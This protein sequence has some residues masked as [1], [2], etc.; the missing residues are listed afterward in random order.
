MARVVFWSPD[1]SMTGTTHALIAVATAMGIN[2]KTS[3]L[4][5]NAHFNSKKIETAFT[6]YY[7]LKES[8]AFNNSNI[9]VSALIRLV[10]SNKLSSDTIKNYAKPV[11]KE[12]LDVLYGM[13][14]KDKEQYDQM[15][16]NMQYISRKAAEAYDVVF[17]DLPKTTS[18]RYIKDVLVDSDI[19]VCVV[20][21]DIIKLDEFFE[22]V[23]KD[24]DLKNKN[25]IFLISDY[26]ASSKYNIRNIRSRYR[27]KDPIYSIPHNYLYSDACNDGAVIDFFYKNANADI[28]DYNGQ[29]VFESLS[30]AEKIIEIAKIKDV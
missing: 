26:E 24:E 30:V 21:Q 6:P 18:E 20:N 23:N 7:E 13:T 5:M 19:I 9:G 16:E 2:Y 8:G 15:T 1:D 27:I 11:L 17:I 10:V 14:S 29:F 22:K 28:R 25:K 12:R 4:I 3:N